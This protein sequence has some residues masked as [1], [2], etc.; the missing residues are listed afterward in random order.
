MKFT[1][2]EITFLTLKDVEM[3]RFGFTKNVTKIVNLFVEKKTKKL[4]FSF[5]V[6]VFFL[7]MTP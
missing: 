5:E 3:L 6:P 2:V 7:F 1:Q 4:Y